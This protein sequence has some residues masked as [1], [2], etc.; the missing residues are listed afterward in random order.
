MNII[1]VA[2]FACNKLS[3]KLRCVVQKNKNKSVIKKDIKNKND[4]FMLR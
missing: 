2:L 1:Q 4:V 3:L